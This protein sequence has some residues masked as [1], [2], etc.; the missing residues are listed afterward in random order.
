MRLSFAA[1]IE[2]TLYAFCKFDNSLESLIFN[3]TEDRAESNDADNGVFE[4]FHVDLIRR[5]PVE[6]SFWFGISSRVFLD[7]RSH[8]CLIKLI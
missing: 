6:I 2:L 7:P 3:H 8:F 1:H 4:G 5:W